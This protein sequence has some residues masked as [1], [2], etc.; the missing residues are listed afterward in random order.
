MA[1]IQVEP[2]IENTTMEKYVNNNNV[3]V[4]YFIAPI[5]GYVIHHNARDWTEEIDGEE[6]VKEGFTTG[7]VSV[8]IIYDFTVNPFGLYT[9]LI[10]EVPADQI[11]GGGTTEPE[12]M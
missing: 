1:R 11:F 12:V 5:E 2:I 9:K 6:V 3:E 10:T 8:P 7:S 4:A